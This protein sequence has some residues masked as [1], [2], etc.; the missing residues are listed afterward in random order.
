[1]SVARPTKVGAM[2]VCPDCRTHMDEEVCPFDGAVTVESPAVLE[3]ERLDEPDPLLGTVFESRYK[4]EECIGRGGMAVVYR[5][6]QLRMKRDVAIKVLRRDLPLSRRTMGRFGREARVMSLLKHPNTVVTYDFGESEAGLYIVME[7]LEGDTLRQRL[8]AAGALDPREAARI[9]ACIAAALAEAH[10]HG[11]VH[12]DL[13]PGN[14]FLHRVRDMEVVKVLDF[15]VAKF[16]DE[17]A[18]ELAGVATSNRL[19]QTTVITG[20]GHTVVGTAAYIAPERVLGGDIDGRAD[21]YTL[22]VMLFEM[23]M[24]YPPYRADA[25]DLLLKEHIEAPVPPLPEAIPEELRILVTVMLA[26]KPGLRPRSADEVLAALERF[27]GERVAAGS[28]PE[29]PK[30]ASRAARARKR[31]PAGEGADGVEIGLEVDLDSGEHRPS[32]VRPSTASG[33]RT[34]A[35]EASRPDGPPATRP[36]STRKRAVQ[37]RSLRIT[38]AHLF[39]AGGLLLAVAAVALLL[40][41]GERGSEGA[42]GGGGGDSSSVLPSGP[43][44][45]SGIGFNTNR[46]GW[47]RITPGVARIGSGEDVPMHHPNETPAHHVRI[48][49]S[50]LLKT[51]EVTQGEWRQLLGNN[52]SG[53]AECGDRCPVESVTWW[54]TLAF[55]NALSKAEGRQLCYSLE[56]CDGKPGERLACQSV[57]F[58]GLGCDGYRLPTEAEWEYAARAVDISAFTVGEEEEPRARKAGPVSTG[59]PSVWGLHDTLGSVSEW[60]WD[61]YSGTYYQNSAD[62]DP[63]GPQDGERRG[64]R[65]CSWSDPDFNCRPAVRFWSP[66]NETSAIVGFRPALTTR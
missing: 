19:Y 4:I 5:A 12:R 47:R 34:A 15:G 57:S 64:R 55:C 31:A 46:T 1:M 13:K 62:A 42:D 60:V 63:L 66:P 8:E 33:G 58:V 21:V 18:E 7:L 50:Y 61:W 6:L 3:V 56:G 53:H 40:S 29:P 32:V 25:P 38:R 36:P 26:K 41:S 28:L 51:T 52:P 14:V 9:A 44:D 22:G 59:Q 45:A 54:D 2:R 49:R 35:P 24:G 10:D 30:R 16:I 27:L 17:A 23:L 11:V 48:T 43:L 37:R 20:S 65:G 39:A